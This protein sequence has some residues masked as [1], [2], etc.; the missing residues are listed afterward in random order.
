V[1]EP[2]YQDDSVTLYHGDALAILREM[3]DQSVDCCVTSP[4]YFGL[5]SYLSKDHPD[6]AHEIGTEE[7]PAEYVESLRALFSEIRRVLATDGTAWLNLGDSYYSGR[8]N[9]G[10]NAADGKQPARRG[11]ARSVDRPGQKWGRPKS[12]LLVPERTAI[13]L[14]DDGWTVRSR[15]IWAKTNPMPEA[16]TDRPTCS[17]EHVFMLTKSRRYY[18]NAEAIAEQATGLSSGNSYARPELVG[19]RDTDVRWEG[20]PQLRRALEL[21]REKGLTEEHFA[22]IRAVGMNDAGK[23]IITQSGAGRNA[24]RAQ[25]LADE[26]K[27]ALG[28]YYREFLTGATRNRRDVW[29]FPPEPFA[30]AHF[31]TFPSALPELCILAGCKPSGVVLDP[32]NGSGTTGL[33]AGRLGH[34]YVGIDLNRDYLDLSLRTRLAQTPLMY[35]GEASA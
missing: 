17:H 1:S 21:A 5:R 25:A 14:A 9:P 29:T 12:L 18:Y 11:W 24:E 31:A 13:A 19:H 23:A 6:K 15:V 20:R 3:A 33:V 32:F 10:P 28:G 8:G 7:S 16:V 2:Y 34:R 30:E 22:A 35:D 26:A 4:P 27:V